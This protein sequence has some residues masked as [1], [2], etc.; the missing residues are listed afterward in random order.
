MRPDQ[1]VAVHTRKDGLNFLKRLATFAVSHGNK[2][3]SEEY[4]F[5]HTEF[6]G[7]LFNS[8]ERRCGDASFNL[9]N[10]FGRYAHAL[11]QL[12][13]CEVLCFSLMTQVCAKCFGECQSPSSVRAETQAMATDREENE[14]AIISEIAI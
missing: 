8:G 7:K 1:L 11:G 4:D 3:N 14:I 12:S 13:L 5:W 2:A 9:A 10:H 6:I